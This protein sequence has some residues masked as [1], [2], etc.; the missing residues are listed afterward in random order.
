M[1]ERLLSLIILTACKEELQDP[2]RKSDSIQKQLELPGDFDPCQLQPAYACL[3][4]NTQSHTSCDAHYGSFGVK[5]TGFYGEKTLVWAQKNCPEPHMFLSREHCPTVG[6]REYYT[7][8]KIPLGLQKKHVLSGY[9]VLYTKISNAEEF[10]HSMAAHPR[11]SVYRCDAS[12]N[13]QE[14]IEFE[15]P[16]EE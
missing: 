1:G 14:K 16:F 4:K 12:G 5:P 8:W 7:I 10:F 3:R 2:G 9:Q 15:S 11:H 13:A 6:V